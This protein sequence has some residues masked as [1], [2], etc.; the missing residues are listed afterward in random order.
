MD[1]IIFRRLLSAYGLYS[2]LFLLVTANVDV[3]AEDSGKAVKKII[4]K[5]PNLLSLKDVIKRTYQRAPE[6]QAIKALV[7][8][9]YFYYRQ[10]GKWPNPVLELQTDNRLEKSGIKSGTKLM[11]LL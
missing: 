2:A 9:K 3:F 8:A 5:S 11:M 4:A 10:S 1:F 6:V 7:R